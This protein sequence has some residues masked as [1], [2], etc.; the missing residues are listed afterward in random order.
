MEKLG[1]LLTLA[2][3]LYLSRHFLLDL[4][5]GLTCGS[6]TLGEPLESAM[7]E[8]LAKV[9]AT[10]KLKAS[11][12]TDL[13]QVVRD[14]SDPVKIELIRQAR[15]SELNCYEYAKQELW[16]AWQAG[17]LPA[18]WA[19]TIIRARRQEFVHAMVS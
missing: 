5:C 16:N 18:E 6:P 17:R 4:F 14:Q 10:R 13:V 3:A 7:R 11:W 1:V 12:P 9:E 15:L 19:Q 8:G 2:G